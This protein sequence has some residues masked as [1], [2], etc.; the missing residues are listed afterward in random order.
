MTH[1]L[2]PHSLQSQRDSAVR[3]NPCLP[4]PPL[5]RL[6]FTYQVKAAAAIVLVAVSERRHARERERERK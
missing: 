3:M 5:T 2:V 1:P 6:P 4:P